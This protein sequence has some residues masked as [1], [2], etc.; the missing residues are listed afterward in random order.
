MK[1][2]N[3]Y[4][5]KGEYLFRVKIYG[6][7]FLKKVYDNFLKLFVVKKTIHHTVLILFK[8][9]LDTYLITN[10]IDD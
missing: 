8:K 1:N 3:G 10:L 5:V 7:L 2:K 4:V 6:T 9:N